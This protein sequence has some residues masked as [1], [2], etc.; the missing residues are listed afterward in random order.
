[1]AKANECSLNALFG[2]QRE[3]AP[4]PA[5]YFSPRRIILCRGSNT[6][7]QRCALAERICALYPDAEVVEMTDR[8]HNRIELD[9]PDALE[10][11]YLGKQTLVL[12]EH[13]SAVRLS[14]EADNTCPNYWHFSP[15]GFCPYDCKY[16]YLRGT[17]GVW[18]SPTVRIFLNLSDILAKI[19]RIASRQRKPMAFYLGKLQDGLATDPLTGYSR[20]MVPFFAS[21]PFA[22]MTLL[23]KTADVQN[24]LDLPHEGHAVLSWSL[25]PPD[26]CEAFEA[27]TPPPQD[28]VEAM[29]QCAAAGYPVRAVIMPVIPCSGWRGK[30]A[31]FLEDLLSQVEL[32]RITLGGICSF[33]SAQ[34]LME[35][36][37][38]RHN[39]ISN[40]LSKAGARSADGRRRYAV[41]NRIE[42][43]RHLVNTIRHSRDNLPI[44]LC[45]EERPVFAALGMLD[46]IGR[47]N[48]VL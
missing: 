46:A 17:K 9:S 34:R 33:P 21:H 27:N 38:E 41:A 47:C 22:R 36:R 2:L 35:A 26:I 19:D 25:N 15:Y 48:C 7:P 3:Y 31:A 20:I 37:L 23:T 8:P 43:Y 4:R 30:Y 29:Q 13:N 39:A 6:T 45:L 10:R 40:E 1:V 14:T 5:P 28:R 32:Q 12:G 42:I 24:L 44:G 18:F 11:H 16:C